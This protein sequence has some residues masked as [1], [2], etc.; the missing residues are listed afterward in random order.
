[1]TL[2]EF[3]NEFDTLLQSYSEDF[4]LG[5]QNIINIDEYEKSI[6]LT[7]AQEDIVVELY[8]GRGPLATSFE[9]SEEVRRYL[10]PLITTAECKPSD[11]NSNE[12]IGSNTFKLPD[13]LLYIVFEVCDT[14]TK[15]NI[16][17]YP[18][19]HDDIHKILHNPFR[20]PSSNRVLRVDHN[21]M[22]DLISRTSDAIISYNI[23]YIRKPS[24]IILVNLLDDVSINTK[25][26]TSECELDS[27]LHRRILE[28]A[29]ALALQSIQINNKV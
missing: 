5:K 23:R 14:A 28:R 22:V 19:A 9:E 24:P 16:P 27:I 7:K 11:D 29:V 12:L 15:K 21:N 17:I 26:I 1:M 6:F 4:K 10:S 25:R 20:G 13:D 8:T 18:V 2:M 3:S